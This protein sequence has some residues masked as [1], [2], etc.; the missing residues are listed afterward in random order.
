[1]EE[2]GAEEEQDG[3]RRYEHGHRSTHDRAGEPR[4]ATL[5]R[6]VDCHAAER[7]RIDPRP[8]DRQ[9]RRQQREGRQ[10]GEPHDDRARDADGAQDH[11]FEQHQA[12]QAQQHR[13]P[14]EED[15]SS[16][17]RDRRGD[18]VADPVRP[19]PVRQLL[20]EATGHEQRVVDAQA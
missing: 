18:G 6:R 4:P 15:R 7:Q 11:E 17:G 9:T 12:Q 2:R 20:A 16:G 14:R 8:D 3:Q 19:R 13:Q 10:D 5:G 1:V